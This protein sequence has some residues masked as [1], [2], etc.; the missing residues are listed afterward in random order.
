MVDVYTP[1]ERVLLLGIARETLE[2]ITTGAGHP[3]PDLTSLPPA[4]REKRACFV[5]LT[6]QGDLRGCTGTLVAR[7]PL[8]DEVA[9]TTAQTA[10]H[11]PR[12]APVRAEE[13]PLIRI[14]ISVLTPPVEL[15]YDSPEALLHSLRPGVDGV[16]LRMGPYRST[17]LPQ[18]WEHHPEPETFLKLLCRKAGLPDDAWKRPEMRVDVYQTVS[19]EEV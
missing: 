4:L 13:V 18:V 8:A 16:L 14:E 5:T 11:D 2:A 7:R 3:V 1:E 15:Q 17:F 9:L 6:E 10:F 19:F 12:F